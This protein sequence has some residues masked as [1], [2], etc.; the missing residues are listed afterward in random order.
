MRSM[1]SPARIAAI[2]HPTALVV[3]CIESEAA[4]AA[5][6][7]DW[8]A[9][10]SSSGNTLPFRTFTWM[11][12]WWKHMHQDRAAVRDSLAVRTVRTAAGRLVAVAPLMLTQRPAIGPI[13]AR[14]L[15]FFGADPNMTEVRGALCEPGLEAKCYTAIAEEL[16]DARRAIDWV[17]WSGIDGL[18]GGR[19]A[20]DD[21]SRIQWLDGVVCSVLD[22]PGTWDELRS[23]RPKNLKESL[24]KC[25]NSLKRDGLNFSLDVVRTPARV[26]PALDD[27]FRLH[28]A[29]ARLNGTV[30]HN[31]VFDHPVRR[32]FLVDLC[33]R[34]A[35]RGALRVFR[36][37]VGDV[38]A[39][40][41]IGFVLGNCLYL[42]YSGFNP[43]YGKYSIMTTCVAEAIKHAIAEG[44]QSVNLSTG[45]DVSK[46]RWRP[47]EVTFHDALVLSP[48]ALP[49][50]KHAILSAAVRALR[51]PSVRRY[52]PVALARQGLSAPPPPSSGPRSG[53]RAV[54]VA[55][56]LESRF[57]PSSVEDRE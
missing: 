25:Y 13:R 46:Q 32:A 12:C 17:R 18:R 24:R 42:Y 9:L 6:E 28:G 35:A 16:A 33:Q 2:S 10:E 57:A 20:L 53:V 3:D 27:F 14:C 4:L 21:S 51:R 56:E 40:T 5:L 11:S 36:L 48:G 34:F 22:L 30:S 31:D 47:E 38:L 52:A 26:A 8:L 7:P 1:N 15:Q 41:R 44:L 50:A 39:A 23:S 43:D 29:R 45:E 54:L 37:Y 49:R 55:P 19:A